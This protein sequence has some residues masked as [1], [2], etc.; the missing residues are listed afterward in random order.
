[1]TVVVV[2]VGIIAL[3]A[4]WFIRINFW[5]GRDDREGG[6]AYLILIGLALSILAPISATLIQLA[7]SRRREYLADATGAL[8]TRYPEGLASALEKISKDKLPTR[9]QNRAVSH[10]FISDPYRSDKKSQKSESWFAVAFST[11]PPIAERVK[12]LRQMI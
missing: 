4:D 2:L 12:K 8:M 5:R 10:L 7:I 9:L 6:G 3:L 1:M 11:H